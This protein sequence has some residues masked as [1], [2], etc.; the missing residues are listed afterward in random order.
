MYYVLLQLLTLNFSI[1]MG[2]VFSHLAT[3]LQ[4]VS[5][6]DGCMLALLQAFW[7]ML[8][9]LFRSEHMENGNLSTAACRALTQ[10][11]QSSGIGVPYPCGVL[12]TSLCIFFCMTECAYSAGQHFLRL[13]PK[14][15]DCL[16]TNFVS[17]QSHECYIRTGKMMCFIILTY[18]AL[19]KNNFP[20]R[21]KIR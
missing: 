1:R 8:E 19:R 10:A 16:S 2:T 5:S 12:C 13:L 6:G 9:K 17:F 21:I 3:S 4:S 11:V 15:L 20:T 18:F 14:V 7:P